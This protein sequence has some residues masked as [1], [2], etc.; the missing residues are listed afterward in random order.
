MD[1]SK[2]FT[3]HYASQLVPF[4]LL[5]D[6]CVIKTGEAVSKSVIKARKEK[7]PFINSGRAPL[8]FIDK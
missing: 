6:I 4:T 3:T 5:G 8:G 7:F 2:D 1:E